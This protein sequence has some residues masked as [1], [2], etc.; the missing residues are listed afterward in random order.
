MSSSATFQQESQGI[1]SVIEGNL[2]LDAVAKV[3]EGWEVRQPCR[4]CKLRAGIT[5]ALRLE[6]AITVGI[7]SSLRYAAPSLGWRW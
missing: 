1:G 5:K 2:A 3:E 4:V 6:V 7:G